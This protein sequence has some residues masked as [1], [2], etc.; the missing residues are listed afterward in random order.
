MQNIAVRSINVAL[1]LFC[2][3]NAP[4]ASQSDQ[5]DLFL[6]QQWELESSS[7]STSEDPTAARGLVFNYGFRDQK[8]PQMIFLG[9][10]ITGFGFMSAGPDADKFNLGHDFKGW[11]VRLNETLQNQAAFMNLAFKAGTNTRGFN[12][13]MP[14]L[15][16][17][18]K[19][20]APDVALVNIAFGAND[21]V[22]Q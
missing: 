13:S 17:Q 20:I 3:L 8:R 16:E 4:V 5:L 1:L 7:S 9:D 14:L 2:I 21:A 12:Q 15:F 10:S 18:L 6:P 22:L 19:T 11:A